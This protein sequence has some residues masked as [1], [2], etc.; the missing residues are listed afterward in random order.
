MKILLVSDIP[1]C[2]NFTAGI[3]LKHL[4]NFLINDGYD[5]SCFIAATPSLNFDIPKNILEKINYLRVEK[6]NESWGGRRFG[7]VYSFIMNNYCS[8][9]KLP[10][11]ARKC[12]KFAIDNKIDK[13]WFVVQGQTT[14]SLVRKVSSITKLPFCVEV[15]DPPE[16]WLHDSKFDP[17]TSRLVLVEF[18]KALKEASKCITTS[19]EMAKEYNKKYRA[20]CVA[21]MPGLDVDKNLKKR[22]SSKDEFIIAITGQIYAIEEFNSFVR[23]L[24]IKK[25]KYHN[26]KIILRLYGKYFNN[27]EFDDSANVE[28]KGWVP[29]E[30]LIREISNVDLL[31]CPY[32]FSENKSYISRLSFPSKL[33]TYLK[34]GVPVLFHGPT[35]SSPYIFLNK[36]KASYFCN[37]LDPKNISKCTDKIIGDSISN[38]NKILFN[39]KTAFDENLTFEV[40]K[41]NF[42]KALD[43]RITK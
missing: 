26:K 38:R 42:F 16:W 29:Q 21:M 37:T 10:N 34:T 17:I 2:D 27:I 13:I 40:M 32:F 19:K 11:I 22:I 24:S 35:Y 25:W 5:L 20:N 6:P 15:W 18:G 41:R 33:T 12:A 23:A 4:S 36:Y 43:L 3:V 28:I 1:P 8:L 7:L 14:I 30:Q 31:Y 39:A 9:F